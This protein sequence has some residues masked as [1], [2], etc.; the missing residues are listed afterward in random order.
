M[1]SFMQS[2]FK[3]TILFI[4]PRFHTNYVGPIN[5]LIKNNYRVHFLAKNKNYGEN[6]S[7][8]KPVILKESLFSKIRKSI[9]GNI[10][11]NN[12][13]YF[14]KI[15][16]FNS[17]I[18][19]IK[20]D[21]AI[22]RLHGRLFT[23]I[24]AV[25][26]KIFNCKV[27]F[28]DQI[29]I[30]T[31]N[32]STIRY[33]EIFVTSFLFRSKIISPICSNKK[34]IKKNLFFIPFCTKIVQKKKF[35]NKKIK[36]LSIGKYQKRKNHLLLIKAVEEI[37]KKND[38]E[39]NIVG[40]YQNASQK[41]F[42]KKIER[43]IQSKKMEKIVKVHKFVKHEN[44]DKFYQNFDLFVL[45][46]EKEIASVSIIEALG[47]GLPVI[48]SND[49]GTKN[50]IINNYNGYIFKK[51]DINSLKEKIILLLNKKRLKKFSL[52]AHEYSKKNI[53][54]NNYFNLLNKILN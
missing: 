45:P 52:N 38:I 13:Q 17:Y 23:Y 41:K 28:Y 8:I 40:E 51:N 54:E 5:S 47:K 18:K 10:G 39:L 50:Y 34:K 25:I 3:K 29:D 46:A 24:S 31:N 27:I 32:L 6:H 44:I 12:V 7:K 20:P 30:S 14:P 37:S 19:K 16:K 1:Q 43:Y 42:K 26:L 53:S 21:Y 2:N 48:C 33:L 15:Y 36:I 9:L 22:I 11:S 35:A 49:C 4:G